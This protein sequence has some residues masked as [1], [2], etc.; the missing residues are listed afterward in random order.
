[1]PKDRRVTEFP[2]KALRQLGEAIR[3]DEAAP[4]VEALVAIL[5]FGLTSLDRIATALEQIAQRD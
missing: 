3:D 2:D 4:P 1:M 5:A